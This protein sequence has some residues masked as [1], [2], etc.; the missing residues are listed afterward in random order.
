MSV[1]GCGQAEVTLL[2]EGD[3]CE[4]II[5]QLMNSKLLIYQ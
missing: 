5:Y 2:D 3:S 4:A 1:E